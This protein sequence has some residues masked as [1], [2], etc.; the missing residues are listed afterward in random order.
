MP[1]SRHRCRIEYTIKNHQKRMH[2]EE[3]RCNAR[4]RTFQNVLSRVCCRRRVVVHQP[5]KRHRT[6]QCTRAAKSGVFKWTISR[7]RRVIG[8]VRRGERSL[9]HSLSTAN[10][11]EPTP[12]VEVVNWPIAMS[13]DRC[14][15][16]IAPDITV[17]L[18]V[19]DPRGSYRGQTHGLAMEP[20]FP[21][22]RS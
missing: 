16:L 14:F 19:L 6:I 17:D 2:L 11:I 5:T 18:L 1:L 15:L 7:R 9:V 21:G 20:P 13:R 4:D 10:Q 12:V 8:V 3:H 22:H